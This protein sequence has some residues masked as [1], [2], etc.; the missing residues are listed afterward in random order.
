M[1]DELIEVF[2]RRGDFLF[3]TR[4]EIELEQLWK[5]AIEQGFHPVLRKE[6]EHE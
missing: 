2:D 6:L 1:N 3:A 5:N 4:T